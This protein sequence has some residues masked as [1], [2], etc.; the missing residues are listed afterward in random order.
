MLIQYAMQP[1]CSDITD[2]RLVTGRRM[3]LTGAT[4]L[5]FGAGTR[6][7]WVEKLNVSPGVPLAGEAPTPLDKITSYNNYY[8]FG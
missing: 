7:A 3:L 2:R 6:A 4:A 1:R 8:E 5:A